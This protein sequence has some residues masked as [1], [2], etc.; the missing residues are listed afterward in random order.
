[1]STVTFPAFPTSK[2]VAMPKMTQRK[3]T[4]IHSTHE[5]RTVAGGLLAQ[6]RAWTPSATAARWLVFTAGILGGIAVWA[7]PWFLVFVCFL[8]A[9]V[10]GLLFIASCLAAFALF[11]KAENAPE[12]KEKEE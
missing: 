4:A 8:Q 5:P 7:F 10:R 6:W 11:S 9:P 3:H 2:G 1:M 12:E